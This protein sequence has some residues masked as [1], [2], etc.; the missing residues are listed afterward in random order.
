MKKARQT[1]S[2][3]L[4]SCRSTRRAR[5]ALISAATTGCPRMRRAHIAKARQIKLF[6]K[7]KHHPDEMIVVNPVL[8]SWP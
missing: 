2:R 4:A 7:R 3:S 1:E 8:N 5:G 6:N